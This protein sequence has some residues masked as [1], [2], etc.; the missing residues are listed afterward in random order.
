M[1]HRFFIKDIYRGVDYEGGLALEGAIVRGTGS[2]WFPASVKLYR[3][4]TLAINLISRNFLLSQKTINSYETS[5]TLYL[6]ND[7]VYHS[8]LGFSY[9]TET[10]EV[11]MFRTTS[12]FSR[13]PYYDSYHNLDLYFEHLSWDMDDPFITM[14]RTRDPQSEPQSSSQS[15]FTTRLTFSGS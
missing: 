4:D 5:S 10:R 9:N 15:H 14:S 2:N 1:R 8:N 3:N 13:S 11:S 6:G 7:S 12:P